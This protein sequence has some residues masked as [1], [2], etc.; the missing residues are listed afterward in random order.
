[1]SEYGEWNRK[2]ATLSD[3][4]ALKEYGVSRE[5]IVA[6]IQAGKLEYR[7]A[8][9]WGN[10]FLRI[11]RRQLEEYIAEQCGSDFLS[12]RKNQSELRKIK[13]EIAELEQRLSELRS[14][15]AELEATGVE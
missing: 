3:S 1:M 6:G 7:E 2:G 13:K 5:F 12:G 15:R 14:R 9:T 4:T 8:S 11:L 10:P